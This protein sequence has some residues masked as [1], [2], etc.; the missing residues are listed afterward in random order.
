M[1]DICFQGYRVSSSLTC[2]MEG[3]RSQTTLTEAR[4]GTDSKAPG[5]P[6]SQVQ[7][8]KDTKTTT[9]FSVKRHSSKI[10]VM[11]FASNKWS[12]KYQTDGRIPCQSV[13]KVSS[14]T[15]ASSMTPTTGPDRK[16]TRLN[17]S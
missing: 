2:D 14:P 3:T 7:K 8:I 5:T 17:S 16:S 12:S 11:R 9:G 10:G 15:A 1:V 4:I 13:S 6:H